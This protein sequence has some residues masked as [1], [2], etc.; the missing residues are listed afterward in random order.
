[1]NLLEEL[2]ESSVA[3]TGHHADLLRRAAEYVEKCEGQEPVG[4]LSWNLDRSE[5]LL[6]EY[7]SYDGVVAS[8]TDVYLYPLPPQSEGIAELRRQV[9]SYKSRVADR[10]ERIAEMDES[11]LLGWIYRS[12]GGHWEFFEECP[13]QDGVGE[14]EELLPVY[15]RKQN[16]TQTPVGMQLVPDAKEE[17]DDC[18]GDTEDCLYRDGFIEGW[19]QCIKARLKAARGES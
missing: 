4:Y 18:E 7:F 6:Q 2:K 13:A 3:A 19:N 16:H 10:D 8:G 17:I 15:A 9:L 12:H 5:F 11:N 1:M 14:N